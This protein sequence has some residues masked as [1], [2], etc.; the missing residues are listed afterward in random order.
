MMYQEQITDRLKPLTIINIDNLEEQETIQD[1]AKLA[2]DTRKLKEISVDLNTMLID[3]GQVLQEG[4]KYIEDAVEDVN[5]AN[6]ELETA[7][8]SFFRSKFCK[9]T[10]IG[11]IVGF[12]VGCLSGIA[13]GEAARLNIGAS[14]VIS[15]IIGATLGGMIIY[16]IVKCKLKS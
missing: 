9:F 5:N 14:C 1:A 4:D 12:I 13:I 2:N 11:I 8:R 16:S 3:Q 10:I 7:K 6:E 15:G